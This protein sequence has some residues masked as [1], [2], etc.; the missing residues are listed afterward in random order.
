MNVCYVLKDTY[1]LYVQIK[2]SWDLAVMSSG[3]RGACSGLLTVRN[4]LVVVLTPIALLPLLLLVEGDVS[5]YFFLLNLKKITFYFTRGLKKI[6]QMKKKEQ[7]QITRASRR[8][9]CLKDMHEWMKLQ[10]VIMKKIMY[11][12]SLLCPCS[13]SCYFFH[14]CLLEQKDFALKGFK[15]V[16]FTGQW[17]THD[18]CTCIYFWNPCKL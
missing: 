7:K 16:E 5:I 8:N 17:Q 15:D 18:F 14:G 4:I 12:N 6:F 2:F 10:S 9:T 3:I 1:P 11:I 13:V